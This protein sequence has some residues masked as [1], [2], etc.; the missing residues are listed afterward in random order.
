MKLNKIDE[1]ETV[2]IHFLSDVLICCHPKILLPWQRDVTTS[3]LYSWSARPWWQSQEQLRAA[4]RLQYPFRFSLRTQT[5]FRSLLGSFSN[6][7]GDGNQDVKKATG[8][9]RETTTLHVHHAFLNISLP[10]M[11]DYDVKM[12]NCKFY[13]GRKQA[14]TNL[15]SSL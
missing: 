10:S 8:L 7:D 11:H 12:P 5:Y 9:L 14:T 13:A 6:E 2:R 3:P 1:V 15:F 4:F